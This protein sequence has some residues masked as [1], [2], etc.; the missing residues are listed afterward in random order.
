MGLESIKENVNSFWDS[1]SEGWH[2][3]SRSASNALTRF[4]SANAEGMPARSEVDDEFYFPS[5][6]W[7]MLGG[8]VFEDEKRVVVRLE[9]P[10]MSKQDI[11][12]KV[13]DNS[14]VIDGEKRFEKESS[15]GRWRMMERAYGNFHRVVP[16]TNEVVAEEAQASYKNGILRVELPKRVPSKPK[17]KTIKVG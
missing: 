5:H 7:A 16:L 9:L 11:D 13:L 12:V 17:G 8:E 15:E 2:Q 3:L 1:V 14:L 6:G 10:G 4:K